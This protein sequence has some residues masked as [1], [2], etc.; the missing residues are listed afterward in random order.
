M[1]T[2]KIARE[3]Y[4]FI[5]VALGFA[6]LS[7]LTLKE[8][9]ADGF[10]CFWFALACYFAYFFRD[11][12]RNVSDEVKEHYLL[13][14][15]DGTIMTIEDVE[16]DDF[17]KLPSYKIVIFMSVF[18]VHVNRSP[19]DGR[20]ICQQY[21]CGRFRPAYEKE[22][23]FENERHMIVLENAKHQLKVKVTQIAGILARRI[24]S[25]VTLD[26]EVKSGQRYGLIRFGS[27]VEVVV[28]KQSVKLLVEEKQHVSAGLTKL[29]EV[30]D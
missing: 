12:E 9:F 14:P 29:C 11:P 22:I 4:V 19:M 23:G 30:I 8:R 16:S 21:F 18:D 15:A 25:W 24:V 7:Q 6:L 26:D 28:P 2:L 3:G 13:S 1:K 27:C 20:I 17:L 5:A 10:A